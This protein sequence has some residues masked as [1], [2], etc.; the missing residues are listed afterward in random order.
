MD[1]GMDDASGS[2]RHN[3]YRRLLIGGYSQQQSRINHQIEARRRRDL[4]QSQD[5]KSLSAVPGPASKV[6]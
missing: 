4:R 1:V 2:Q 5:I 3:F 6:L